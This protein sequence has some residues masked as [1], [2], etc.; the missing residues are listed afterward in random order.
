MSMKP[1]EQQHL[2]HSRG[3]VNCF[4]SKNATLR[5][6]EAQT[7][8]FTNIVICCSEAE[9]I[10]SASGLGGVGGGAPSAGG[11]GRLHVLSHTRKVPDRPQERGLGVGR[12]CWKGGAEKSFLFRMMHLHV[13]PGF[14]S[15]LDVCSG[16]CKY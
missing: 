1:L 3:S 15:E 5:S 8:G 16:P 2:A 7:H 10:C 4:P 14:A 12:A 9:V 13:A 6:G 11:A